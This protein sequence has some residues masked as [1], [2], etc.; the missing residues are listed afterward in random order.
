M[1]TALLEDAPTGN[2]SGARAKTASTL[3]T[4]VDSLGN[5]GPKPA[6]LAFTRWMA[7]RTEGKTTLHEV[8]SRARISPAFIE[9]LYDLLT[10]GT[11]I[12][13]TDAPAMRTSPSA[14]SIFLMESA[15]AK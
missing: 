6:M 15:A 7:V 4:V 10:P 9:R 8:A 12:V 2:S 11:T 1:T 13:V 14:E 3:Q 5:F